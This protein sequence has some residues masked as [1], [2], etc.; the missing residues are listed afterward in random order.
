MKKIKIPTYIEKYIY[1]KD[2]TNK[3]SNPA[4]FNKRILVKS[5]ETCQSILLNENFC[6]GKGGGGCSTPKYYMIGPI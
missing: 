1:L 5:E 3:Y 6:L 4:L 2:I